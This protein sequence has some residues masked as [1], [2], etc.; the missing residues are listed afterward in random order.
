MM[1]SGTAYRLF[2][3]RLNLKNKNVNAV[4]NYYNKD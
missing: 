3:I 1:Q 2:K 4:E